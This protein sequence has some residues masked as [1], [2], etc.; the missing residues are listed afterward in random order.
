M[1][2]VMRIMYSSIWLKNRLLHCKTSTQIH[3]CGVALRERR[4]RDMSDAGQQD[5]AKGQ[6]VG[7]FTPSPCNVQTFCCAVLSL[8]LSMFAGLSI[9]FRH[10]RRLNLLIGLIQISFLSV[11]ATDDCQT[12]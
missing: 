5:Y 3:I 9:S 12:D 8:A 6:N 7:Y 11:G 4:M 1:S 2:P 10:K